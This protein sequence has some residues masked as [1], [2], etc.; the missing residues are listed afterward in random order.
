MPAFQYPV[1]IKEVAAF[2]LA[3]SR[4]GKQGIVN[5]LSLPDLKNKWIGI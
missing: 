3:K 4:P 5:L 1:K 2:I